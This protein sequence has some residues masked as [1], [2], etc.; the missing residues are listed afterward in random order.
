[1]LIFL[2]DFIQWHRLI[3]SPLNL[4]T[5]LHERNLQV[6]H[7]KHS[8]KWEAAKMTIIWP[9]KSWIKRGREIYGYSEKNQTNPNQTKMMQKQ[10]QP[11]PPPPP[12]ATKIASEGKGTSFK[13]WQS[14]SSPCDHTVEAKS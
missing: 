5:N 3:Y 4:F 14:K 2:P 9:S 13:V 11:P 10:Q 6:Y 1:M 12:Q 7:A 8:A